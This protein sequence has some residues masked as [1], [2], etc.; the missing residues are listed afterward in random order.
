MYFVL[1]QYKTIN[2]V[3]MIILG[4]LYGTNYWAHMLLYYFF[5][6]F[7]SYIHI[8]YEIELSDIRAAQLDFFLFFC[9]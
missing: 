1:E 5:S 4:Y 3:D 6:I 8:L 2:M 7:V 9:I